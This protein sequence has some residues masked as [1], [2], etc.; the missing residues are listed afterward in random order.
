MMSKNIKE[1]F[2]NE[3]VRMILVDFRRIPE[4]RLHFKKY[5]LSLRRCT[6]EEKKMQLATA[7]NLRKAMDEE[8]KRERFASLVQHTAR[9]PG[10]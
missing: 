2:E 7:M 8:T 1:F 5:K 4:G 3:V 10:T 6:K 9:N